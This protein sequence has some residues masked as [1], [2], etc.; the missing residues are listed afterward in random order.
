MVTDEAGEAGAGGDVA[1]LW[2]TSNPQIALVALGGA[3]GTPYRSLERIDLATPISEVVAVPGENRHLRVLS[4]TAGDE[5]V[6]LDL[7]SRTAAPLL[8]SGGGARMVPSFDG[9][10]AW[11]IAPSAA[12]IAKVDFTSLH[13]ENFPLSHGV[14]DVFDVARRGGGRAVIA[15]HRAGTGS[16]TVLDAIEPSLATAR[17]YAGLL[18]GD[19]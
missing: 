1:L 5:F 18:L 10:R 15:V 19:L 6:V 2:S 14:S 3:V 13:P 9:Q 12:A 7:L 11:L 17:E 8:A 4:G 16:V